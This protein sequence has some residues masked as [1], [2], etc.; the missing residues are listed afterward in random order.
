[1]NPALRL[2][3]ASDPAAT[4]STEIKNDPHRMVMM[5]YDG[6]ILAIEQAHGALGQRDLVSKGENIA[7]AIQIIEEGLRASLDKKA[8][9]V[10]ALQLD[11]LYEYMCQRLLL[12]SAGNDAVGMSEVAR[13]LADLRDAWA[14]LAARRNPSSSHSPIQQAA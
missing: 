6:A 14:A 13:L 10:I 4:S 12:S 11:S 8:G 1:M 7:K 2:A 3:A 5:L 9:D